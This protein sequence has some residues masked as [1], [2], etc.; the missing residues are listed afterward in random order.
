MGRE[1]L[2]AKAERS[3]AR[4]RSS[5]FDSSDGLTDMRSNGALDTGHSVVGVVLTREYCD[6]SAIQSP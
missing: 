3:R 2:A 6:E 5:S 4:K 1:G